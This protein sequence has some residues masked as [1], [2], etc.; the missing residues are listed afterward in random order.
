M[1]DEERRAMYDNVDPK[2][3]TLLERYKKYVYHLKYQ[4]ETVHRR[5]SQEESHYQR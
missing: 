5:A 1:S 2:L 3:L 4:G